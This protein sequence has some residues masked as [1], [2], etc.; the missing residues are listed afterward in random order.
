M[1]TSDEESKQVE[2]DKDVEQG[3]TRTI[4][5]LISLGRTLELCL[6]RDISRVRRNV[7]TLCE[8]V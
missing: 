7:I 4:E 2:D 8:K 5:Y 1:L 3:I 6:C